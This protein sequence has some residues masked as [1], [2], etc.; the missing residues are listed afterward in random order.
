MAKVEFHYFY[1]PCLS[2]SDIQT[3]LRQARVNTP[4]GKSSC[5][6]GTAD[7]WERKRLSDLS[8]ICRHFQP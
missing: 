7:L 4:L 3:E 6:E 5:V 1:G 2:V 8:L